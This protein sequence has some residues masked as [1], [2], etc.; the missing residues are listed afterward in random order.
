MKRKLPLFVMVGV[1]G[2]L[3]PVLAVLAQSSSPRSA[4][5]CPTAS[6]TASKSATP[7]A[8]D[9]KVIDELIA[10]LKET[11]SPETFLVTATVLGGMG[12]EA[13]RTL[14][15]LIRNAERLKLFKD[16]LASNEDWESQRVAQ[17]VAQAIVMVADG[18]K[19]APVPLVAT[20]WDQLRQPAPMTPAASNAYGGGLP[21]VPGTADAPPSYYVPPPATQPGAAPPMVPPA[22]SS[23]DNSDKAPHKQ[24]RY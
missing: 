16:L 13:K 19:T 23:A 17:M 1:A 7:S 14:P 6:C 2:V 12:P 8:T 15:V 5:C 10:I 22:K 18:N 11:K 4:A 9:G 3:V 24:N 20:R 21:G